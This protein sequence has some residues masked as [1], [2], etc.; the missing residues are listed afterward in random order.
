MPW[1]LFWGPKESDH[2]PKGLEKE[3]VNGKG[4]TLSPD[5]ESGLHSQIC[6]LESSSG[7]QDAE[8]PR[9]S[10]WLP[11]SQAILAADTTQWFSW[12]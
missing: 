2:N 4:C 9:G 10:L 1:P 8:R 6:N 11:A 3:N 12:S 7:L 5:K